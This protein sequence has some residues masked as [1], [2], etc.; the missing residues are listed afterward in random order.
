[1]R[2]DLRDYIVTLKLKNFKVSDELPFSNSG[3]AM[4]LK[5]PKTIYVEEDQLTEEPLIQIMNGNDVLSQVT[6]VRVYFSTDAKQQPSNYATLV[7]SIKAWKYTNASNAYF[8][9]ECDVITEYENDL[10]VT[11]LEFRFTKLS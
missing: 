3:T 2:E 1:M 7:S 10:Q 5:N 9:K 6:T 8:R 11:T 4:F